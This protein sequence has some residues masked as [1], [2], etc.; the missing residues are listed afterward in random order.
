[1]HGRLASLQVDESFHEASSVHCKFSSTCWSV[2]QHAQRN[3]G[4]KIY[5]HQTQSIIMLW[6][7][8]L[9]GEESSC[10]VPG[11]ATRYA[12]PTAQPGPTR[13]Q[14]PFK[15]EAPSL[16]GFSL[17]LSGFPVHVLC[18]V[19]RRMRG[20]VGLQL[21]ERMCWVA[22]GMGCAKAGEGNPS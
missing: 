12:K 1:M 22:L 16:D 10:T 2:G 21:Y 17:L 14:K 19:F 8:N 3:Y 6:G 4:R 18:G 5:A 13:I 7:K 20:S 9:A 11:F 15:F